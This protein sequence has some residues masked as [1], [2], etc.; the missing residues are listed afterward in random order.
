[1]C[2]AISSGGYCGRNL[3]IDKS[4]TQELIVT[5]R[6]K[7]ISFKEA[8]T[9][10]SHYAIVGIGVVH[11]GYPLYFD[12]MNE[13]GV[14]VAALNYVG[15]A[16]YHETEGG[17]TNLAPYELIP[18]LLASCQ[19]VRDARR[20]LEDIVLIDTPFSPSL[21]LAELHFFIADRN[22]S[23]T[24]EPDADGLKIHDNPVGVLTNN[25]PFPIQ[26]L[27]LN[28][29]M[30]LSS[31]P[32]ENLFAPSLELKGYSHGM[33]ALGLPGDLSSQSRFV[34]AAYHKLNS[35]DNASIGQIFRL[36]STVAMPDGSVQTD[37]GYERT[38]YSSAQ[39]LDRLVYS[40]RVYDSLSAYAVR[41]PDEDLNA[42]SLKSY[43]LKKEK[44]PLNSGTG[45]R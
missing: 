9:T 15:N 22:G 16:K 7:P 27:N 13:K 19:S 8:V 30:G 25:P 10:A 42:S 28:N 21:P 2:T 23:I 37:Y 5:P 40:Y 11:S 35:R 34:R 3:D 6:K 43:R 1:M 36:L 18:Y 41:L 24:V 31:A 32:C 39:D 45:T 20:E 17:K 44:E 12:A 4:Y 33:G 29:Y 38:E 14:Y 26:M